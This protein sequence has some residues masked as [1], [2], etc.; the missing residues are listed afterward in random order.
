LT[1]SN[2][3]DKED[4]D[5]VWFD[6]FLERL[7]DGENTDDDWMCMRDLGSRDILRYEQWRQRGFAN[8]DVV[9]L[10]T[11]NK[12]VSKRNLY[13]LQQKKKPIVRINSLNTGKGKQATPNQAGGLVSSLFLCEGAKIIFIK[14]VAQQVGLCNG[15]TGTI[16]AFVFENDKPP[17]NLPQYVIVDFGDSYKGKPLFGDDTDKAGWVPIFPET[18]EWQSQNSTNL[19]EMAKHSRSMLPI[20]LCYAW[21]IW[22]AQ[23]QTLKCKIVVNLGK[24]K[25]NMD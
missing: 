19:N 2:R 23:G 4:A 12:E 17:P 18:H 5:A 10:Y 8:D 13:C 21:T 3:L 14:N 6:S 7:R 24:Q 25:R 1:E 9:H 20:R 15:S 16:A 22:K 11:T